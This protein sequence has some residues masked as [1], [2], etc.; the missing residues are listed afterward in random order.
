MRT[1]SRAGLSL[2]DCKCYPFDKSPPWLNIDDGKGKKRWH[3]NCLVKLR[4]TRSELIIVTLFI[5]VLSII[6]YYHHYNCDQHYSLCGLCVG[7]G[8]S[9]TMDRTSGWSLTTIRGGR[10][11]LSI[12]ALP[13]FTAGARSPCSSS[14]SLS[15]SDASP[16]TWQTKHNV[17]S[18][19]ERWRWF[20]ADEHTLLFLWKHTHTHTEACTTKQPW[21]PL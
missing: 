19:Q 14:L 6:I 21:L 20:D 11:R 15:V 4:C 5:N 1:V 8:L 18:W 9:S 3:L 17:D 13:W 12:W 16:G 2:F 10:S 7:L